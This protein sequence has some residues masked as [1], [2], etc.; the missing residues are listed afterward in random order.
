LNLTFKLDISASAQTIHDILA[1][2]CTEK[3]DVE[4][5]L[6][7]SLSRTEVFEP[8]PAY[9]VPEYLKILLELAP[10]GILE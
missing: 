8:I 3:V 6:V 2:P 1:H 7:I 9:L 5:L 4:K 10:G